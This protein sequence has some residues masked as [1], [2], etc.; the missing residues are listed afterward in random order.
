MTLA[1]LIESPPTEGAADAAGFPGP[2]D[3]DAALK[4]FRSSIGAKI[5]LVAAEP[6]VTDPIAFDWAPDGRLFVVEMRDYPEDMDDP[7][8]PRGRVRVLIDDDQDGRYDRAETFLDA[9]H[10]PTGVKVWREGVLISGAPEIILATDTDGDQ[11]ADQT[12]VLFRGFGEGN[13]QHR[14][15]GLRWGIDNWLYLAN[16]DSGGR[17]ESF[18]GG[19]PVSLSGRDLRIDPDTGRMEA[20]SGLTQYGRARDDLGNWFGGNNSDPLWHYVLE[21]RYLSR[22]RS[23]APPAVRRQVP[24]VPGPAPVFPV[25]R[26]LPRFN[27]FDRADRFTSACGHLVV[28]DSGFGPA[29]S[30]ESFVC[31]PVHNL[32]HRE[33]LTADG[34][35]FRSHRVPEDREAEFLASTDNWFRPVLARIGPD[36][37]IWI[38]D[39]YRLVIE[40]P[41]WIPQHW[42]KLLDL[43]PVTIEVAFIE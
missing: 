11:R 32:V 20:L 7:H 21:D 2:L 17:I 5:E 10:Y 6:L 35:S 19:E 1:E 14:I 23:F 25:S 22:N 34:V 3:P 40:H 39:M 27:D 13:Q 43:Q 42:Q 12:K 33:V 31:E 26:T 29:G 4:S 15:N 9:L 36:G 37:A 38:A 18:A 30:I 41:T 8:P 24:E 16:G 28:H